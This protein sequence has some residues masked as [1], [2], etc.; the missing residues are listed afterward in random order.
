[1]QGIPWRRNLTLL[2]VVQLLSTA[3]FSLV[4]PFL[5]LYFQQLGVASSGPVEFWAGVV[6]SSQA[7]VMMIAAPIWGALADRYGRKLM[8]VRTTLGSALLLALMGFARN[9]EQLVLLRTLQ[10]AVTGVIPATSAL[11]AASTPREKTGMALGLLQMGRWLGVAVGPLIGGLIGDTLGF[12]A[13]FW[14][15]SGMLG[16]AGMGTLLGVQEVFSPG[17]AARRPPIWEAYRALVVAPGMSR[18]YTIVFFRELVRTLVFPFVSL[19]V[20]ELHGSE[21]GA[22]SLTG[23]LV[24]STAITGALSAFGLGRLGDRRGHDRVLLASAVA[25]VLFYLPQ[26]FV[27][28]VGPLIAFQVAASGAAGGMIASVAALMNLQAPDRSQGSV[29]GLENGITSAARILAPM[30]GAALAIRFGLRTIFGGAAVLYALV[31]LLSWLP[32]PSPD[33]GDYA[34]ASSAASAAERP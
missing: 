15:T 32:W 9:V 8:I 27:A 3:G 1:M 26:P 5:P 11:V 14:V 18:L 19:F 10:G 7:V 30:V 12:R 25:A 17:E 4:F 29:Y 24:G 20:A 6:F 22:A 33:S 2:V 31:V 21:A 16:L 13:S 34:S 23:L 28:A